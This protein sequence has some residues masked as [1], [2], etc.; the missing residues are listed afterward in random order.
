M[1]EAVK[2]L[3]DIDFRFVGLVRNPMDALYSA[4]TRWRV[5]PEVFQMHWR[6]AY[7]NLERL[8]EAVGDRLVI[9]RYED[10]SSTRQTASKLL[11]SLKLSSVR[12]GADDHIHGASRSRWKSDHGF[13]FQLNEAVAD[14]AIRYGYLSQ[15][16][17]N[18]RRLAWP[19][20]RLLA[21][22]VH[23]CISRPVAIAR[24]ELRQLVGRLQHRE[25]Q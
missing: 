15:D 6:A 12:H 22:T 8:R 25:S 1:I 18:G 17:A 4:W 9:V 14:L 5:P 23:H 3:P 13:G 21:Q 2:T 11:D 19:L 10:F 24:R 16:L 20:R 7:E